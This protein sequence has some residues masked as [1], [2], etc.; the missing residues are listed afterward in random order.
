MLCH[1][2]EGTSKKTESEVISKQRK[3]IIF[4]ISIL[5]IITLIT[6]VNLYRQKHAENI[7]TSAQKQANQI[8]SDAKSDASKVKQTA[9]KDAS[10]EATSI[11]ET[12]EKNASSIT[13]NA[14]AKADTI[15]KSAE[16]KANKI[17][18]QAINTKIDDVQ[19]LLAITEAEAGD[20]SVKGKAAVAA[21]IK[22]RVT[23]DEFRANSIKD[24]VYSPGQFQA[25]SNGEINNVHISSSTV[26]GVK[27][28][29]EGVDYSNGALYF[30]NPTV[31]TSKN[32]VWF[33]TL[34]TTAIIGDH[35]F[36]R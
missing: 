9:T 28:C 6:M 4:L 3:L 18:D 12:A 31:S 17:I 20:Q 32:K 8:I 25:V 11:T 5:T 13:Q 24:V 23:S 14:E 10:K 29:L 15:T 1:N 21:T 27:I 35:V 16:D 36:K 2:P 34:K 7:I 30:Y 19:T 33:S 22:N 26:E